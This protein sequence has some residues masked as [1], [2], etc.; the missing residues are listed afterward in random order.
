MVRSA[1]AKLKVEASRSGVMATPHRRA[2]SAQRSMVFDLFSMPES[3]S[4]INI[5]CTADLAVDSADFPMGQTEFAG[6]SF[7][8]PHIV[9]QFHRQRR[10]PVA[11]SISR[12]THLVRDSAEKFLNI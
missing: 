9:K 2:R 1:P 12:A 4:G 3:R 10:Q 5:K 8:K 11:R 6:I 7:N